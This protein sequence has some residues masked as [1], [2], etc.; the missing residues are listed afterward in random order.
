[1]AFVYFHGFQGVNEAFRIL[2]PASLTFPTNWRES[3]AQNIFASHEQNK[4]W[5]F[6]VA[7]FMELCN[8]VA[9]ASGPEQQF[10]E[11]RL[12]QCFTNMIEQELHLI[13]CVHVLWFKP[14]LLYIFLKLL[15]FFILQA[16]FFLFLSNFIFKQ[17]TF[18]KYLFKLIYFIFL[19]VY[20][21]LEF[22]DFTLL[23]LYYL[24]AWINLIFK[25]GYFSVVSFFKDN[26][27]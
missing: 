19:K 23:K 8:R 3:A 4:Q 15:F 10:R 26:N 11:Y 13:W 17:R 2:S 7:E 14:K 1:M 24:V 5:A 20:L 21:C 16:F 22:T 18:F 9:I 6:A 25:S 12:A 27:L